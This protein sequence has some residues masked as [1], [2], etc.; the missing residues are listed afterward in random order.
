MSPLTTDHLITLLREF[1]RQTGLP[2]DLL[3]VG[4]LA[5]QAYGHTERVTRDV[6]GELYGDPEPLAH[7]LRHQSIPVDLGE[8]MS[9]WA[10]VAMPPG[11]RER[12]ETL[13]EEPNLHIRLLTPVDFILAKLRRGT[14][15]D[16]QD[17]QWM[18]RRFS[19][20]PEDVQA[21]AN[22]ALAASPR[23]TALFLFKQTVQLF[24]TQLRHSS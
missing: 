8:N 14:E 21:S 6:D 5:L 17:A 1:V 3:L 9:G 4:G 19:I 10:V 16:L 11:Y 18:A 2:V 12:A 24:C 13:I 22:A 20:S 7:F 23:D 15:L